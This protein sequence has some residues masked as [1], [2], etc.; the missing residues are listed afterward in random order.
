[1]SVC[2]K[3][4][5]LASKQHIDRIVSLG[6]WKVVFFFFQ[7]GPWQEHAASYCCNVPSIC[8]HKHTHKRGQVQVMDGAT[9]FSFYLVQG[10]WCWGWR[11]L[12][13][14]HC[15]LVGLGLRVLL[16]SL[17]RV[18]DQGK[19]GVRRSGGQWVNWAGWVGGWLV[20]WL[21]GMGWD[22]MDGRMDGRL[23]G[24]VKGEG[25]SK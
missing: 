25:G 16:L 23:E 20:G 9:V 6:A 2:S 14:Y 5:H 18:W 7:V 24:W 11:G 15:F 13:R 21:V 3:K 8:S 19:P 4:I 17:C 10:K 1:M 12:N 22:G